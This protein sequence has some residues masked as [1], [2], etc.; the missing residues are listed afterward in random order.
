MSE[1]LPSAHNLK[2]HQSPGRTSTAALAKLDQLI[3]ITPDVITDSHWRSLPEASRLKPLARR[4][5][6]DKPLDARLKNQRSTGIC[7]RKLPKTA[8]TSGTDAR[9]D[10]FKLLKFAGKCAADAL[11]D[12]PRSI[13]ILI[14]GLSDEL[15]ERV[16]QSAILAIQAHQFPMPDFRSKPKPRGKLT[17]IRLIGLKSAL[18]LTRIQAEASAI[19]LARWLTSLP[20]NKLCAAGFRDVLQKLSK[21]HGWK[22]EFI[23]ETKLRRL[24][25]GA[26][27]AVS[28][29]NATADAGIAHLR[30]TPPGFSK[31]SKRTPELALVGKGIIFDTGGNNLKPF[32]SML[33][34]H[35]DMGGSAVAVATL[36]ALT[37]IEFPYPVDCWL[38]ITENR[39][40]ATAYKSRDI[41]T[42]INGTTIEVIH[43]DAEGRMALADTLALAGKDK[44]GLIID[45]ATLTGA[46]AYALT[47]RYSGVF[48]NR[49]ALNSLLIDAGVASGE[50]VWPFPM[51]ADFEEDLKSN[52]ADIL[53]CS[54]SGDGD[55]ILA[56]RFLKRFVPKSSAWI[57]MDLSAVSRQQGLGQVPSGTTGFG[58]RYTLNLLLDQA[59]ELDR[60]CGSHVSSATGDVN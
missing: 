60:L 57:H 21:T 17:S 55:Q 56:A 40:D 29:G 10:A 23:G 25:A 37:E 43:T 50:R 24:G 2:I 45:Y 41:V 3:I 32:K 53:Q 4:L 58:I 5:G 9:F 54:V 13:G 7:L 33:D 18:D 38:A 47:N 28:Q 39:I 46:C 27:L 8:A 12:N 59:D 31:T 36:Q 44:P 26:F 34:M 35:E 30:Y 51:D 48:T 22:M 52:I 11:R 42:A 15:G 14:V 16:A 6:A 49:A 20:P 1:L 19:N